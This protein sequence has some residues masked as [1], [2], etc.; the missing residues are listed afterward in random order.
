MEA[1]GGE[2]IAPTHSLEGGELSVSH[3]GHA[4]PPGIGPPPVPIGQ[5]AG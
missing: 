1:H 3:P 2:A 5:E 4:L